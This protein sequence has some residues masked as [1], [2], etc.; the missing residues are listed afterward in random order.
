MR[1]LG[2]NGPL[3]D[4]LSLSSFG[5]GGDPNDV[6][7]LRIQKNK[8]YDFRVLFRRDKNFWD[9]NLLANPLNPVTTNA[10]VSPTTP[11]ISSPHALDL[12]RRMQDYDLTLFPNSRIRWRLG[13]SRNRDQGPGF[14]TTDGGTIPT[15]P[16]NFSYTTNAYRA[17]VDFRVLPRTTISY[18]QFL[19]YFQQNNSVTDNPLADPQNFGF[20]LANGTPVDLGNVWASSG[21]EVLPCAAPIVNAATTPPTVNPV[22]YTHLDVY[23]RQVL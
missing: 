2:H 11:I 8:Y 5:Y 23:K 4:T 20:Q 12:V 3:F 15:F 1:S 18:D 21:G 14:F 13:Y 19:S 17:G 22:S 7:R 9:W 16:E 6:S 10:A